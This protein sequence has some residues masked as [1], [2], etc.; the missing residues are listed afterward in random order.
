MCKQDGM[1]VPSFSL[2]VVDVFCVVV[3]VLSWDH[4]LVGSY[5]EWHTNN[6]SLL[7]HLNMTSKAQGN[8]ASIFDGMK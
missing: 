2:G 5:M 3:I 4:V 6:K 8:F 1:D 7:S